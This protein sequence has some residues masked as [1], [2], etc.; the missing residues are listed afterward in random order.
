MAV[1]AGSKRFPGKNLARFRG[2]PLYR[3][4][5]DQALAAGAAK[6]AI[7]TDIEEVLATDFDPRVILHRRPEAL[8]GDETPIAAVIA[9]VIE[10]CR[11][12]DDLVVLLQATSPLRPGGAIEDCVALFDEAGD[13]ERA[14]V[15]SV[16]PVDD[17]ILKYGLIESGRFHAM[18][19]NDDCFRNAQALPQVYKPN[20]SIY[21][22]KAAGFMERSDFPSDAII[23]YVM[24]P[25]YSIDI[26][27]PSDL[28]KI[29]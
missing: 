22:F 25:A 20:G 9:D 28:E 14:M 15:M 10:H 21:V 16:T 7:S 18:R 13:D 12:R 11:L 6:V 1:R 29:S 17:A 23:S 19:A 3:H 8:C 4:T 5:V 26:D 2:K 27:Y 24:D